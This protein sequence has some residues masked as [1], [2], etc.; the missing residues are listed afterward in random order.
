MKSVKERASRLA[1][2]VAAQCLPGQTVDMTPIHELI[3]SWSIATTEGIASR[4]VNWLTWWQSDGP[5]QAAGTLLRKASMGDFARHL[6]GRSITPTTV[7]GHLSSIKQ[8]LQ[9]LGCL[10]PEVET[11]YERLYRHYRSQGRTQRSVGTHR[12]K[13]FGWRYIQRCIDHVD[14]H[15]PAQI[16]NIAILLILYDAM[17]FPGQ[18]LGIKR[19]NEWAR[20][21]LTLNDFQRHTDG[22]GRLRVT[23]GRESREAYLSPLAMSWL[24]RWLAVRPTGARFLFTIRGGKAC[25][26]GTW[27]ASMT[28]LMAAAGLPSQGPCR[29]SPKLGMAKDLI[30]AGVHVDDVRRAGGWRKVRS[31]VRLFDAPRCT[32]PTRRLFEQRQ[33]A[34]RHADVCIGR[35]VTARQVQAAI[36]T[37]DLFVAA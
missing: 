28:T 37:G 36:G 13:A 2:E 11:E 6:E 8:F 30:R 31:V 21:P 19:G 35:A 33:K 25:T 34:G 22:S 12:H 10:E 4:W 27:G 24:D 14:M 1:H 9:L 26:S 17:A 23:N 20:R 18:L 5:A 3:A 29:M 32:E 16:R 7:V 15:R